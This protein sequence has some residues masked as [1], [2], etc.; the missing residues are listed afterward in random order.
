M[1]KYYVQSGKAQL[2]ILADN[3]LDAA[4]K[5]Y[6]FYTYETKSKSVTVDGFITVGE[7]GF[8]KG[9]KCRDKTDESFDLSKVSHEYH[10]RLKPLDG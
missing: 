9:R 6:H 1:P 2:I 8:I 5:F 10:K 7:K 4:V 3:K